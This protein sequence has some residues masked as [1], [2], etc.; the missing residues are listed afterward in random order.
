LPQTPQENTVTDYRALCADL[1]KGLDE[2]RHPEVR[3]PGHLRIIMDRARTALAHPEPTGE[4]ADGEWT[5]QEIEEWADAIPEAPLEEMDPEVHGWRR[6][7]KS[8]EF[9]ATIRAAIA[10]DRSRCAP[11]QPAE[12]EVA[13]LVAE[14]REIV[15][16]YQFVH[17]N[18]F[19]WSLS[20]G[21]KLT[22]DTLTRAAALLQHRQPP[23]PVALVLP[24]NPPSHLL[25]S[26]CDLDEWGMVVRETWKAARRE[27]ERQQHHAL[28]TP[29]TPPE[30]ES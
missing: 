23:Q 15:E 1:L 27:V 28:P 10:L 20:P 6:C 2:N 16:A 9:A 13:E 14:L 11:V 12:G 8:E 3:Y 22:T 24:E 18:G 19:I 25:P 30:T 29:T 26:G 7:F 5:D 21:P 4:V 17:P